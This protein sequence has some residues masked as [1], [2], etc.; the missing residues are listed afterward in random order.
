P[1]AAA[2]VQQR[3]RALREVGEVLAD[4]PLVEDEVGPVG[5]PLEAVGRR[6]EVAGGRRTKDEG[7]RSS[8]LYAPFVF[9]LSSFVSGTVDSQWAGAQAGGL[10]GGPA[11]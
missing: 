10:L 11:Q 4:Q 2:R 1:A 8:L 7:R 9:R 6:G 5:L 3:H